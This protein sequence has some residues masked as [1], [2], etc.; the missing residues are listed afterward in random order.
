MEQVLNF[1]HADCWKQENNDSV[2]MDKKGCSS[3]EKNRENEI[4]KNII[5]GVKK[6]ICQ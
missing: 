2:S 4:L 5:P 1:R 6:N 3:E